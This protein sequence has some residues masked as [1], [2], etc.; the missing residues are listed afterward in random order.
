MDKIFPAVKAVVTKGNKFLTVKYIIKNKVIWDLPGGKI[1][2]NESP[3]NALARE[4]YEETKLKIKIIK[5]IGIYWFFKILDA[6]QA[7]C[8]VFLC[9]PKNSVN[10]NVDITKNPAKEEMISEYK[11][12]TK[13]EFL[14]NC[15]K[16][17]DK[18]LINLIR[19]LD[20]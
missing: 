8:T 2:Y 11:W 20:I 6:K 18:S 16:N 14:K 12:V 19:E 4:V 5:P 15:T 17:I 10:V 7:I 9:E 3:Y 1:E 13:N